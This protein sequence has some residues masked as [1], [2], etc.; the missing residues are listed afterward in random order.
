MVVVSL[1]MTCQCILGVIPVP[2]MASQ[3]TLAA[4]VPLQLSLQLNIHM[5]TSAFS[6]DI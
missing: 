3:V 5:A 6:C 4:A 1:L 2:L